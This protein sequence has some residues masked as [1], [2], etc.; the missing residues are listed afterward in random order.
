[1]KNEMDLMRMDEHQRLCWLKANRM[2]VFIVGAVWMGMIA[3]ELATGRVP[4][5]LIVMLP[6]L[7][8][9]RLVLYKF[10]IRGSQT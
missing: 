4:V 2:M 10:Y 8:L 3:W 1:M 9:T 7:A 5:F 6:A